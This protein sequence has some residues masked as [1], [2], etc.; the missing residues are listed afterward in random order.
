[1]YDMSMQLWPIVVKPQLLLICVK[2]VQNDGVPIHVT[3]QEGGALSARDATT[4]VNGMF[5]IVPKVVI[6]VENEADLEFDA[7]IEA[8][9]V[10]TAQVY[11]ASG[12]TVRARNDADITSTLIRRLRIADFMRQGLP[13]AIF[14]TMDRDQEPFPLTWF[15]DDPLE[16]LGPLVTDSLRSS[17]PSAS[18]IQW[19]ALIYNIA[20]VLA[21][22]PAKTVASQIRLPPRTAG[23]WIARARAAGLLGDLPRTSEPTTETTG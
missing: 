15:S 17:G 18:T 21:M 13:S 14:V 12:V 2:G 7:H 4:V 10:P 1:M 22:P 3:T 8:V 16:F 5:Q 19:V 20:Q 23:N 6:H 9:F 11:R